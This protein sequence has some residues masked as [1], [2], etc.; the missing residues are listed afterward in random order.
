[1]D[2]V[3]L[4]GSEINCEVMYARPNR[5]WKRLTALLFSQ[6]SILCPTSVVFCLFTCW[7]WSGGHE[8]WRTNQDILGCIEVSEL[9]GVKE[10]VAGAELDG[11]G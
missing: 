2:A 7:I 1:M 11:D 8:V 5:N 6:G 10:K 4:K 9:V 3:K